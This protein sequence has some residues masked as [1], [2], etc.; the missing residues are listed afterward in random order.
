MWGFRKDFLVS[1]QEHIKALTLLYFLTYNIRELPLE[2]KKSETK[3]FIVFATI[4]L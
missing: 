2:L 4:F 1:S 3:S